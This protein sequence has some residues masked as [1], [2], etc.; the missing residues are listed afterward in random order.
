M[1]AGFQ[2]AFLFLFVAILA[3]YAPTF[4]DLDN[5][6]FDAG[7]DSWETGQ[8]GGSVLPG[9]VEV[10]NGAA[11]LSEGDSFLT[12][13]SQPI[14]IPSGMRSLSFDVFFDPGLDTT[15]AF[16]LDAFEVSLLEPQQN[17]SLVA[18][19]RSLATSFFN[20]SEDGTISFGPEVEFD[21]Q[22]VTV[23]LSSVPEDQHAVLYFDLVGGDNDVDSSVRIDNVVLMGGNEPP[24]A[25]AG[26]PYTAE[27]QG[28]AT[29]VT[30]NGNGSADPDG[31][32]L[33]YSWTGP[34]V[35]SQASGS[36][37]TLQFTLGSSQAIT[38][39][40][41]DG[42]ESDEDDTTVDVSDTQPPAGSITFPANGACFGPDDFPIEVAAAF[43][44]AC[45][46]DVS[47]ALQPAGPFSGHEDVTV[48]ATGTDDSGLTTTAQVSFS[49]DVIPPIVTLADPKDVRLPRPGIPMSI[50]F[51]ATDD[52][53]VAGDVVEERILLNTCVLLDGNEYG[54]GDGLLSDENVDITRDQLIQILIGCNFTGPINNPTVIVEAVDCGGNVGRAEKS[55][56]KRRINVHSNQSN[57]SEFDNDSPVHLEMNR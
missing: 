26:G 4:A 13:L 23:D 54:D 46:Q 1:R 34:F 56:K 47:L 48:T 41:S 30:V 45:D 49:L 8:E 35:G 6:S 42:Q 25:D 43:T 9:T 17:Q 15:D 57:Q 40:V 27:C 37:P 11:Q 2:R 19:W 24:I 3:G 33:T 36:M 50:L 29:S 53:G 55:F 5:G 31:D 12:T 51:N 7:L 20:V 10:I 52:D 21:G 22:T 44:D 32:E 28:E 39:T 38:L 14:V 16:V 18:P